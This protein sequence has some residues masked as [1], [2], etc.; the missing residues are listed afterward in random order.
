MKKGEK[1]TKKMVRRAVD[2]TLTRVSA[3]TG[4]FKGLRLLF[5]AAVGRMGALLTRGR[6]TVVGACST[7]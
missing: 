7:R 3:L 6:Y 5:R 1:P 4:I 2:D